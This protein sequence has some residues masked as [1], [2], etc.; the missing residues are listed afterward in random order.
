MAINKVVYGNS[1]LLDLT[2]DTVTEE[3]VLNSKTFHDK[4]GTLRTGS[5]TSPVV[6]VQVNDVSVVDENKIAK[7]VM[8]VGGEKT[9]TDTFNTET[10]GLLKECTVQL[11]PIQDL[12]GYSNPW[13]GGAGKNKLPLT[14]ENLKAWNTLGTWSG[15]TYTYRMVDWS[16]LTD[17]DGNVI[18]INANGTSNNQGY[19]GLYGDKASLPDGM[20]V[21]E[22]Y[23]LSVANEIRRV[24]VFYSNN[25]TDWVNTSLLTIPSG[26]TSGSF[27]IPNDATGLFIRIYYGTSVN[28]DNV[29][30]YPMV[31]L[32]SIVDDT[33][34]SYSNICSIDG[35]TQSKVQK[36]SKNLFDGQFTE[37]RI[38]ND[39]GTPLGNTNHKVTTYYISV[40]PNTS[41]TISGTDLYKRYDGINEAKIRWAFYDKNKN[42][43]FRS[44]AVES[45]NPTFTTTVDTQYVKFQC[46]GNATNVQFEVGEIATSYESYQNKLFT[47]IFGDKVY[48]G[49]VD[50][51]SGMMTVERAFKTLNGTEGF[52]LSAQSG[53]NP[54]RFMKSVSALNWDS[55][56]NGYRHIS[57]RFVTAESSADNPFGIFRLSTYLV[58][59]DANSR[60][61]D[62]TEFNTWLATQYA[63]GT[64]VE[65]C[66]GL[67]TPTTIKL[68]PQQIEALVGVNNI[69]A[70]LDFQEIISVTYSEIAKFNDVIDDVN[71]SEET[72]YS[73]NKIEEVYIN[74]NKVE[75]KNAVDEFTTIDGGLLQKC[76]VKLEP[77][78]DLHG[79]DNPWIGG[80]GKNK[81]DASSLTWTS[82]YLDD[83]GNQTSSSISHY[84]SEVKVKPNQAYTISGSLKISSIPWRLYYRDSSH[85]W[86]ERTA[87]INVSNAYNFV[88]PENCEYIQIQCDVNVDLS[89]VQLELGETVTTWTPYSNI[90][91]INGHTEVD[92]LRDGK[93]LFDK[94]STEIQ[95]GKRISTG[96][97]GTYSSSGYSVSPYIEVLSD[98]A[99]TL[100][101]GINSYYSFYTETKAYISG[102]TWVNQDSKTTPSTAKY[103]RFDYNSSDADTVQFE[104]G[105]TAT[106]YEPY[107]GELYTQSLGTTVYEGIDEIVS[108]ELKKNYGYVEYDGSEDE[109]IGRIGNPTRFYINCPNDS[110][111][112]E[113][114]SQLVDLKSNR[115]KAITGIDGR[116][117]NAVGIHVRVNNSHNIV[118]CLGEDSEI[119]TVSDFRTWL[120][121]NLVQVIYP[122][123]TS[124]TIQTTSTPIEALVGQ[125]NLSA[126]LEGQEVIYADYKELF[127]FSDVLKVSGEVSDII[128]D[129]IVSQTKTWSSDKIDDEISGLINDD[130][131]SST[132]VFSSSKVN[133]TYATK[134]ELSTTYA[135][136][137]EVSTTYATKTELSG[138]INDSS[139]SSSKTYSSTKINSQIGALI[140]DTTASSSKV[141][142]STKT[143]QKIS[144]LIDDSSASSSKTYSSTKINSILGTVIDD[145]AASSSKTY[146]SNKIVSLIPAINDTTASA[147]T[148]YS[149]NKVNSQ[150]SAL[151]SD[152]S[153]SSSKTYS[154]QKIDSKISGLINDS[155]ASASTTYSSNKI[156]SKIGG[157][158][159]DSSSS[160][161]KTYSSSKID[162]KIS[163][164]INDSSSSA[165][166]T[167]SSSKIEQMVG[168]V[169]TGTL[170]AS[171]TTVTLSDSSI[172]SSSTFDIYTTVYG[173]NPTNVS[174][175]T[176][177][178]TLTFEAQQSDVGV[179]V[180]VS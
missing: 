9:A 80:A 13:V 46:G 110:V 25:G 120:Q 72:T 168:K 54:R 154:S 57:D 26:S 144:G 1:T 124:S 162:T 94:N 41:Y 7:V 76:D 117:N 71:K 48:G 33:F 126:P 64:P 95:T 139:A 93:N 31:R 128:D 131:A 175:S 161:S 97:G 167:Y 14:I 169:L 15:N 11:D 82:G 32:S 66:Y 44:D 24:D 10:G 53:V 178:I 115:F 30:F 34:E 89:D 177:S 159:D 148:V 87:Q 99:Y 156:D 91:H 6:D 125:N 28:Y 27:T 114:M 105:S 113:D 155:S 170:T 102:G 141:Y 104:K 65:I 140:D 123:D 109:I 152:S 70:P 35:H 129:T 73:S 138:I 52:T 63:N 150:I 118:F 90:C 17:D 133:T 96:N 107:L 23:I 4:S 137:S 60:F 98:T 132:K 78:Q 92:L 62:A 36:R 111:V 2:E 77:V 153:S 166:K 174:V 29:T 20:Q 163:G 145:T 38:I 127:D 5:A 67:A 173:L 85:T 79:Y 151:I 158:I 37:Q 43:I 172:T 134:N 157:I 136:K 86:I 146:S 121:N 130:T 176:G 116:D 160:A 179:K 103:V 18:G 108:G 55:V 147:T 149:S 45:G 69:D 56:R 19:F 135:T 143:D 88:T 49:Y 142:S 39:D 51:V 47:I 180:R 68:T 119:E 164:I 40:N 101:S 8:S 171:S 122:L 106:S 112:T 75:V 58:F 59:A 84:T 61:Q 16:V 81:L 42:F 22:T 165:S 12:H 3:D 83:D 50:F 21:G 100:N 74:K